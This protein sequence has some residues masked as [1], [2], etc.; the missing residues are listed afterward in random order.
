MRHSDF[1]HEAQVARRPHTVAPALSSAR[2]VMVS[3]VWQPQLPGSDAGL[4]NIIRDT[5]KVLRRNGVQAE[6]WAVKDAEGLMARL[7][8]EDWRAARP[9][10]HVVINPPLAYHQPKMFHEMVGRWVDVEFV[11]L[12]HSGLA[13]ISIN[14]NAFEVIRDLL[15]LESAVHNFRVAGNNVRYTS[16]VG[17]AFGREALYLPNLYDTES[18]SNPVVARTSY[19]PLRIGSFGEA[20]P[21]K[22][23]LIAAEAALALARRMGVSL[24][25]YVNKER[26]KNTPAQQQADSRAQL[27]KDIPNVKLIELPWQPWAKF[28]RTIAGMDVLFSPSFDETFLCVCAD[29]IAEGVPSV[30]T[31]AVEWCPSQWMCEP[32]DPASVAHVGAAL[33]H[34]KLGA[35]HDGRRALD[36]YVRTGVQHWCEYLTH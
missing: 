18:Y 36:A 21:W 26:W 29:G 30:V 10:T 4:S 13:Y 9:I 35:V 22:N 6:S 15:D 1:T 5:T 34:G 24:E 25:L 31:G 28:R 27:F 7:E 12:N 14:P 19:D 16:W 32:W 8:A 17:N 23:Q 33:L 3:H 20:R 2:V 11:Q